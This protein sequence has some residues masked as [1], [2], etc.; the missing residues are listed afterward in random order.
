MKAEGKPCFYFCL[1]MFVLR[2]ALPGSQFKMSPLYWVV[3]S[4]RP[5]HI[6]LCL[7]QAGNASTVRPPTSKANSF[8]TYMR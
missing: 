8:H 1:H 3:T 5:P 4:V 7:K 2:A 6:T